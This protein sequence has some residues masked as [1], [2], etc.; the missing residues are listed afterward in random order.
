MAGKVVLVAEKECS[1]EFAGLLQ[2][3]RER[4]WAYSE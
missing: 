4:V 1:M 3:E 2:T